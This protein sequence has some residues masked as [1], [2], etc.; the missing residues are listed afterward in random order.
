MQLQINSVNSSVHP[1]EVNIQ[2]VFQ[3][4]ITP[5]AEDMK[6]RSTLFL[7]MPVVMSCDNNAAHDSLKCISLHYKNRYFS[8]Y[9]VQYENAAFKSL[10]FCGKA[11]YVLIPVC[12]LCS[13]QR[14]VWRSERVSEE[15]MAA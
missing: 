10:F 15:Q 2:T 6:H 5:A 3:Q 9:T 8:V 7:W 11:P 14:G 4:L 1:A 12:R 13:G